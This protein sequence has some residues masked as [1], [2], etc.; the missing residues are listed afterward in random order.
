MRRTSNTFLDH[1]PRKGKGKAI[2]VQGTASFVGKSLLVAAL[3]RIFRQDGWSVAPF[4]A[5]NMS[6]N[7]CVTPDG[8]EIARAQAVQ[9][10]AAGI[11]PEAIMNP[12]LLKPASHDTAQVVVLGRPLLT[13]GAREYREQH[14]PVLLRTIEESLFQLLDRFDV[15]VIE[16]AGSPAEVNLRDRDLANMHVAALTDAPVL[17]VGDVDR[18]GMLASM[19]GT[20][21]LLAPEERERIAGL[22]VNKFRGDPVLLQPGLEFLEKRTGKPVVGVIPYLT[23]YLIDDEDSVALDQ[24]NPFDHPGRAGEGKSTPVVAILRLPRI[25][26]FTDFAPLERE[27]GIRVRYVSPGR[28]IGTADALIVPGSKSTIADLH[29]LHEQGYHR[30]IRAL[31]RGG[32]LILGICGGY[33]MLGHRLADPDRVEGEETECAGLSLLDTVT[34][35]LPEKQTHQVEGEVVTPAGF[36]AEVSPP[37]IRGYEIHMGVTVRLEGARPWLRLRRQGEGAP[38]SEEGAIDPSGHILGTYVHDVFRN[39]NFRRAFVSWLRRQSGLPPA[40][41][42]PGN[43]GLPLTDSSPGNGVLSPAAV[44]GDEGYECLARIVRQNLDMALIYRLLGLPLRR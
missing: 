9:A 32:T 17:L 25:A 35:F 11:P 19:V 27:A 21:E 42:S 7:S 30:E 22:V 12:V 13:A 10:E 28:P 43:G 24:R 18:G 38:L 4:K 16:G 14:V 41:P 26:N 6:L 40:Y 39:D 34:A 5:Q 44:P 1:D 15:V 33:Q 36:L 2:M 29:Y 8:R 37:T 3:C 31:A 23:G 20:L